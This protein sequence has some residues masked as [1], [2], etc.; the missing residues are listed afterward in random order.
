MALDNRTPAE[1]AGLDLNLGDNKWMGLIKKSLE[2]FES[3]TAHDRSELN[4]WY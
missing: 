4:G 2:K 1:E 3:P